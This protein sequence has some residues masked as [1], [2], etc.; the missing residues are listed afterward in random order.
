MFPRA[1]EGAGAEDGPWSLYPG[2]VIAPTNITDT[3]AVG[4]ATMFGTELFRVF[5]DARIDGKLTVTGAIDP[6]SLSLS[7]GT[8]LFIDSANGNTAP[9]SAANHGR[10][11]YNSTTQTWQVSTNGLAYADLATTN[12]FQQG[13]NAFGATAVLGTTDGFDLQVIRGGLLAFT[14][15]T[16]QVTLAANENVD[17]AAGTTAV[18]LSPGTGTF[19]LTTG[20][21]TW[22]SASGKTFLFGVSGV[23]SQL[24]IASF[25]ATKKWFINTDH[26]VDFG[27]TDHILNIG[28]NTLPGGGPVVAGEPVLRDSWES[29]FSP[30]LG[31]VMME[32]HWQFL[33]SDGITARR[34]L[35]GAVNTT[36]NVSGVTVAGGFTIEDST[37][38]SQRLS[39]PDSAGGDVIAQW[40][41]IA[42]GGV[43]HAIGKNNVVALYQVG[44]FTG[45]NVALLRLDN[46][47]T[48]V[49]DANDIFQICQSGNRAKFGG[50]VDAANSLT[51]TGALTQLTGAVSLSANAVSS[52]T[53]SGAGSSLTITAAAASTWSTTAG[54]LTLD[55]FAGVKLSKS[56]AT[57]LDVGVT[58]AST[59]TIPAG[60]SVVAAAGAENFDWSNSTGFFKF[61][62]GAI[63]W[64]AANGVSMTLSGGNQALLDIT[65]G[66][67]WKVRT[68]ATDGYQFQSLGAKSWKLEFL[69][70]PID[71][72]AFQ[73]G[74]S[75]IVNVTVV[76]NL[77][78]SAGSGS[79]S[80]TGAG[81]VTIGNTGQNGG[82]SFTLDVGTATVNA[83]ASASARALNFGTGNAVQTVH[84]FDHATPANTIF[85]GGAASTVTVGGN[86]TVSGK[87]TVTGAID[88][89][90]LSLS[91]GT[92]LF[93]DSANGNTSAV[94]AAGHGR[95]R[96]DDTTKTWQASA[97]GVA[98]ASV[99]TTASG[100]AKG[101]NAFGALGVLGTTDGF[102]MSFI[103]SGVE[104]FSLGAAGAFTVTTGTAAISIGADA[105]NKTITI[106]ATSNTSATTF[107]SGTGT[108]NAWTSASARTVNIATG[109]AAQT[110]NIATGAA[111]QTVTVGSTNTT[112]SVSIDCG[113]GGLNLATSN[114]ART[115]N[116][117]TGNSVQTVNI[118]TGNGANVLTMGTTNGAAS[119]AI[120]GGSSDVTIDTATTGSLGIL[121]G[122][123][124]SFGSG[125]RVIFIG[126]RQTA[127]SANPVGGGILYAEGGAGKWRGSG[128]TT[129]TFGPADPHCPTCG[130]D[131]AHEWENQADGWKLSVC[132]W[133]LTDALGGAGVIEKYQRGGEK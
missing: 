5:G 98:Y 80:L 82:A 48:G 132:V 118:A 71:T 119:T 73:F 11:R 85:I 130:R 6:T 133:C 43:S 89:P 46:T 106:G 112:S 10:I 69:G 9:V 23:E 79:V 67:G 72:G 87:L 29:S 13:G 57:Y 12:S 56:G 15:A 42:S 32:R 114:S 129:T 117:A 86:M 107:D 33:G 4:I 51:V 90:S 91:G 95:L 96:Y 101:G 92:A 61:P 21:A 60:I 104:R 123:A 68:S 121:F 122:A 52:F 41:T 31:V 62:Q 128:G 16:G 100:F 59:L 103:T 66:L 109:G 34:F 74:G 83:W 125:T 110:V 131:C 2:N 53:A 40:G 76:G 38:A 116:I 99:T 94:A 35:S 120:M 55:G 78:Q 8:A 77:A 113:T 93:I 19:K 47:G 44:S 3:V 75:N 97:D 124:K 111:A 63:D 54:A 17:C 65:T 105:T 30:S 25:D 81:A 102:G 14:V 84:M 115:T 49:S 7:G 70:T 28:W 45:G 88:P 64:S 37:G 39:L 36:T 1:N 126:N 58:T 26:R 127:P 108:V 20:D 50:L 27:V 22:P 24:A 18:D